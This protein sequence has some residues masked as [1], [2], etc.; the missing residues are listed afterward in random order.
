MLSGM[1]AYQVLQQEYPQ[2]IE[3]VKAVLQ[4][5]PWYANQWQARLQ[6]VSVADR[7][8]GVVHAS[9]QVGRRYSHQGQDSK[10]TALALHQPSIQTRAAAGQRA[11]KRTRTSEHPD[12]V[13]G[14]RARGEEQ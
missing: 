14:E 7:D 3:K 2:T 12:R 9:G 4:K 13:G 10:Q 1:I 8:N 5:Y 11:N 6:D